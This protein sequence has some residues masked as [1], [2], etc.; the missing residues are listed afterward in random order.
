MRFL[1]ALLLV[2]M[3]SACANSGQPGDPQQNPTQPDPTQPTQ[4]VDPSFDNPVETTQPGL[5]SDPATWGG[6]VPQNGE[7]V[8]IAAGTVVTLDTNTAALSGLRIEG[9]LKAASKDVALTSEFIIVQGLFEIGSA[10]TPFAHRAVV[11]LTGN[12]PDKK[13]PF[14]DGVGN[15]VLAVLAGGKLELHGAAKTSWSKL[16]KTALVGETSLEV[17]DANGWQ[18]GDTLAVAPSDFNPFEMEEVTITSVTGNTVSFTPALNYQHWGETQTQD[19]HVLD[20]RAEVANLN[21]NILL[22]SDAKAY[23]DFAG[24]IIFREGSSVHLDNTEV[25]RMG[26]PG[27]LGRY[28]LH[29]HLAKNMSGS[30]IK[31]SSVH[32][33]FQR[34]LVIHQTDNVKVENNTVVDVYGNGY[35]LEDSIE[36]GNHFE[37][38]LAMLI[39]YTP[40]AYR[41]STTDGDNRAERLAAF[42]ITNSANVFK[43]NH[44]VGVENG[45]G[46]WFVPT[47]RD[48]P[49]ELWYHPNMKEPMREFSG[50]VA[51]TISFNAAPPDG[52]KGVFNLGYGPEEAGTCLRFDAGFPATENIE[53]YSQSVTNFLAY[54]CRNAAVWDNNLRP[55]VGV[56][57]VDSRTGVS[58]AQGRGIQIEL[59]DSLIFSGS[60]NNPAGRD[61]QQ[62][63]TYA[64]FS[65]S[66]VETCASAGVLLT[67]TPVVG[68][69]TEVNCE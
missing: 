58:N 24:H 27:K 6:R 1:S 4:P 37:N 47:D 52:G 45:M 36:I 44:A 41:L 32:H 53:Q 43:N 68:N 60:N 61:M 34:G 59:K 48:L 38:N 40:R 14:S 3:L 31:N 50:N 42:W 21:R 30:Y 57:L 64:S 7:Y 25:T 9:E 66:S 29:F 46:Y 35:Y 20:M 49:R 10:Q 23:P 22:T 28:S 5:W 56:K 13:T 2:L 8:E 26:Q 55:L 39:R 69:I 18:V 51:H 67:N 65:H 15:K 19:R 54:K 17:L 16:A 33:V 11:T 12:N 63:L 62:A